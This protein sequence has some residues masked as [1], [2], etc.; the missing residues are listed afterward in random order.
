MRETLQVWTVPHSSLLHTAEAVC[1]AHTA[2]CR[3]TCVESHCCRLAGHTALSLVPD[4]RHR[5]R[6]LYTCLWVVCRDWH[7]KIAP[8]AADQFQACCVRAVMAVSWH[9]PA[10]NPVCTAEAA[11]LKLDTSSWA[12]VQQ[13]SAGLLMHMATKNRCSKPGSH[14]LAAQHA[15]LVLPSSKHQ[16][17]LTRSEHPVP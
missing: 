14:S 9:V 3:A 2:P 17:I 12:K 10:A 11:A 1:K 15:R 7:S 13:L 6:S 16:H 4:V 5:L 8:Q